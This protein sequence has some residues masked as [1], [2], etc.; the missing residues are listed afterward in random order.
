MADFEYDPFKSRITKELAM[1]AVILA[2]GRCLF[3]TTQ[4]YMGIGPARMVPGDL[5]CSLFG[6]SVPFLLRPVLGMDDV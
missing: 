3:I 6:A 5:V 4:G 1:N 2:L